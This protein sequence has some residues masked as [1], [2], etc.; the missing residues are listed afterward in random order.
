MALSVYTVAGASGRRYGSVSG[1]GTEGRVGGAG[2]KK[3]VP[4]IQDA[5]GAFPPPGFPW[6]LT[7]VYTGREAGRGRKLLYVKV[8]S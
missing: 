1:G 7:Q 4:Y 6:G 8:S 5:T 3:K 2:R